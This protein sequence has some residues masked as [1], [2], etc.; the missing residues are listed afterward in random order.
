MTDSETE[1]TPNSPSKSMSSLERAQRRWVTVEPIISLAV[2]GSITIS[3]IR[4][5]YLK[6]RLGESMFNIT[7]QEEIAKC[8]ANNSDGGVIEDE[9]QAQASLWLL[10]LSTAAKIPVV[11]SS[12]ILGTLSDRLG[13]K[14]CLVIPIFGFICQEIVYILSVYYKL[15]LPVLLVGDVIQGLS[16]GYMSLFAGCLSYIT[17]VTSEKQRTMRIAVAEMLMLLIGGIVQVSSGYML[18]DLGPIPPLAMALGLNVLCLMYVAIPGILIDTVDR[19]T[20]S[21]HRKGFKEAG[22]S[23]VKLLKFNEN[24][25]RWQML[26][27]DFF[28]FFVLLNVNGAM[29]IYILYGSAEPFCWSAATAGLVAAFGLIAGSIG[30]VAGTKLFSCCLDEYWIMQ[31][32]CLS[33]LAFDVVMGVSQST[34]LVFVGNALGAL[35]GMGTPVARSVL[36]TIVDPSEIGAAFSIVACMDTI[37]SFSATLMIPSI[38]AA[39]VSYMPPLIFYVLSGL[40]FIPNV[41]VLILQ[42]HWPRRRGYEPIKGSSTYDDCSA[43]EDWKQNHTTSMSILETE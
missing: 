33:S 36:S 29:S 12:I 25:R 42:I 5:F 37:S 4:P 10:Y 18:R 31:I 39:T 24:G 30:M 2:V 34:A 15:P 6:G 28:L 23:V 17:D 3:L 35:R 14:L 11:V 20:I 16:G 19:K 8:Q 32:S 43:E 38:Y 9:I 21:E 22:M 41:I 7:E 27:L 1:V 13:R 26:L 40:S